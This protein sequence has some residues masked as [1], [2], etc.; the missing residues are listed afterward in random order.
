MR[1]VT[2]I[3]RKNLA[4]TDLYLHDARLIRSEC[5]YSKHM[6]TL[7]LDVSG[8]AGLNSNTGILR[9]SGLKL[10]EMSLVEPWMFTNEISFVEFTTENLLTYFDR[11]SRIQK[12]NA[13]QPNLDADFKTEI[14]LISGDTVNLIS[15]SLVVELTP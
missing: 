13:I 6:V 2:E 4:T 9:F 10:F 1:H 14:E 15:S 5:D 7:F 8:V 12:E 11:Y 3:N